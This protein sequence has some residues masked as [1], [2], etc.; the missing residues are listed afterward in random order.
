MRDQDT[1]RLRQT[2]R[3]AAIGR[4][5]LGELNSWKEFNKL[6]TT[7]FEGFARRDLR[8]NK[9]RFRKGIDKEVMKFC[10]DNFY[11]MTK[12]KLEQLF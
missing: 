2:Q 9:S 6:E 10:N 4:L 8:T 3:A 7:D 1:T 12:L 5:L 11:G